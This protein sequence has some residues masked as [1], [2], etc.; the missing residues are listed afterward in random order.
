MLHIYIANQKKMEKELKPEE[1]IKIIQQM[2]KASQQQY[3]D[4]GIYMIT[5]A[6]VLI[7]GAVVNYFLIT[8]SIDLETMNRGITITW[9]VF[10]TLGGILSI[11]VGRRQSKKESVKTHIGNLLKYMWFGF[12]VVL[13]FTILFPALNNNSP[14]PFILILT[15]F[16]IYI[17]ALGIKYSPFILGSVCVL[18]L[19][20]IA[21]WVNYPTQL[22][23]FGLAILIGYLIPGIMLYRKYNDVK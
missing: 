5:W 21:F 2:I 9:I 12:G 13:F 16:V 4:N 10:P 14:I 20:V 1:S 6:I 19:G 22:L 15:S 23:A 11:I 8:L 18:A 3:A 7:L 17:F